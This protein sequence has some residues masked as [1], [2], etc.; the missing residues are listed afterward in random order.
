MKQTPR[1]GMCWL[2]AITK[3]GYVIS[4]NDLLKAIDDARRLGFTLFEVEGVAGDNLH[5]VFNNKSG[6]RARCRANGVQVMNFIPV[7]PDLM[8]LDETKRMA[9]LADFKSACDVAAYFETGM[10]QIDTHY[11]PLYASRPY[12][13]SE[14]FRFAYHPPATR[15]DAGFNF[16]RYFR[17]VVVDSV[18]KCNEF[19]LSSG[20]RLCIEPR[21]WENIPNVWALELLL[22]EVGSS[23]VGAVFDT[24]HLACQKT[25]LVQAAEMLGKRIFYLHASD[26]DFRIEDHLEIGTGIIDWVGLSEVL[27]KQGFDGVF[28]IDVGGVS[29]M[30]DSLDEMYVRSRKFLEESIAKA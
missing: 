30:R 10:I 3:Y 13:I 26:S 15:L 14:E 18:T 8:S 5:G 21:T 27:N 7:L 29:R 17:N 6:I 4:I 9:A 22:R 12:D 23:N 16:W 24:A 11:S 19:A 20:L 28:G 2:Y 1:I 25:L